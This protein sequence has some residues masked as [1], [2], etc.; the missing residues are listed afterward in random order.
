MLFNH[1]QRGRLA[2]LK[3]LLKPAVNTNCVKV[4]PSKEEV[5]EQVLK[6]KLNTLHQKRPEALES[7]RDFIRFK[8]HGNPS[9]VFKVPKSD[10]ATARQQQSPTDGT[11]STLAAFNEQQYAGTTRGKHPREN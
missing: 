7:L 1:E 11:F 8:Q 6:T 5:K 3:N 9:V 4:R 10:A 2:S